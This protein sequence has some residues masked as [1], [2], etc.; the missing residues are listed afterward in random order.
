M[1]FDIDLILFFLLSFYVSNAD[2]IGALAIKSMH[3]RVELPFVSEEETQIFD[4]NTSTEKI[5]I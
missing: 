4:E 1:K 3:Q 5:L 2:R